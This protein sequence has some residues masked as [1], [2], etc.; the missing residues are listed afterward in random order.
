MLSSC[1]TAGSSEFRVKQT[2]LVTD[3]EGTAIPQSIN[4][5]KSTYCSAPEDFKI[6]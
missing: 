5:H 6:E 2:K 4:K 1:R 3:D